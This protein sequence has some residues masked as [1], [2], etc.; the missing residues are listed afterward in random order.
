MMIKIAIY[1][2]QGKMGKAVLQIAEFDNDF[3]I[4]GEITKNDDNSYLTEICSK[5]DIVIDFSVADAI[6]PLLETAKQTQTKLL[7]GTTGF[8]DMQMQNIAEAAK[9][10]AILYAPNT[11]ITANL[12]IEFAGR[13]AKILENY[14]AE[15]IDYHHNLKKD[16]PSGTAIAIG[17]NIASAR[18][19]N[20][21]E[22]ALFNK[23]NHEQRKHGGIGFSSVRAG[24]IFGEHEV[25]FANSSE[26]FKISAKAL[27]RGV[28][29]EGA[30]IGAKWLNN[31]EPGLY[32]MRDI[33][34]LNNY[35]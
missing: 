8:N 35:E 21:K 16:S 14:D 13:A 29:A 20:F 18:E 2:A 9:Y 10:I 15:I 27:T 31:K 24:G 5:S 1:G 19:Q 11:S 28:F 32:V 33:L 22:V 4:I 17:K 25:I 26:L 7:I 30:L 34:N 6:N 3:S 23:I 12:A